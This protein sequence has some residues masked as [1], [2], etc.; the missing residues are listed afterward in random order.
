[1]TLFSD[2]LDREAAWLA[3]TNDTLP[4]LIA[5]GPFELVQARWPR[6]QA[7]RK[8]GLYVLRNP[9]NSYK[10][11]R[12]ADVRSLPTTEIMLRISWPLATGTGSGEASQLA[13]EQAI[14]LVIARVEGLPFD[15]THGGR[16]LSVAEKGGI[17]VHYDDPAKAMGDG[18]FTAH[19][20][21]AADDPDFI[22]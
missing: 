5:P 3:T 20:T 19:I 10:V 1:M 15:K 8:T 9:S 16:F 17:T 7:S 21:Y 13:L 14:D 2:A 11:E 22:N 4:V 6:V 12:F 18:I